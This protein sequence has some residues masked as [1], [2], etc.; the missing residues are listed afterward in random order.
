MAFCEENMRNFL[1]LHK[2]LTVTVDMHFFA[3]C[4]ASA[5]LPLTINTNFNV[6]TNL[7]DRVHVKFGSELNLRITTK[8]IIFT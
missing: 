8:Q 1:N 3:L 2:N 7:E 5:Q 4:L 6:Q